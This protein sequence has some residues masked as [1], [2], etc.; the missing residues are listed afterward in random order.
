VIQVIAGGM[1]PV[2]LDI[3]IIRDEFPAR[4]VAGAVGAIAGCS[5]CR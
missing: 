4:K 2:A 3:I 1:R 5:A